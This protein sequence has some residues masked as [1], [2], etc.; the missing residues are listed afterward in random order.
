M[1]GVILLAYCQAFLE[2]VNIFMLTM[3]CDLFENSGGASSV[4][5]DRCERIYLVLFPCK[6]K[7]QHHVSMVCT[8]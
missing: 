4:L 8:L 5:P 3:S 1:N 6:G 2:D 7:L